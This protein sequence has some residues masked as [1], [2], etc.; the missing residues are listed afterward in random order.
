MSTII[1][2]ADTTVG[3]ESNAIGDTSLKLDYSYLVLS[4]GGVR[5]IALIGALDV[6]FEHGA[7]NKVHTF[8]GSS[9][10][11]LIATCICLGYTPTEAHKIF[12]ELDLVQMRKIELWNVVHKFGLD[13]GDR[14]MEYIKTRFRAKDVSTSITFEELFKKTNK[15]LIITGTCIDKHCVEYFGPQTKPTMKIIDAI[16]I[17]ISM[18]FYF[19]APRYE[20]RCYGDGGLLDNFPL[21]AIEDYIQP[22]E[23]VMGIKL[24]HESDNQLDKNVIGSFEDY[25]VNLMYTLID[26]SNQL[27][28]EIFQLKQQ[29]CQ[30]DYRIDQ[31]EIVTTGIKSLQFNLS[32]DLKTNLY[33]LG[34]Y[35]MARWLESKFEETIEKRIHAQNSEKMNESQISEK[36]EIIEG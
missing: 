15:R 32:D 6:L 31:I 35:E 29:L 13:S 20:G 1:V 34:R 30:N 21:K 27:R 24:V 4:G 19:T 18:P 10:G 23:H 17:S 16:R 28:R 22:G 11:S 2:D 26:D 5:G 33:N 9:I 12:M 8:I 7:L 25:S 3:N 14:I 36:S